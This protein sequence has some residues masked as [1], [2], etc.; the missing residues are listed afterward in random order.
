MRRRIRSG[1]KTSSRASV[2]ASAASKPTGAPAGKERRG[3]AV[4]G[5]T[6]TGTGRR[7][8]A[9]KAKKELA[10]L[11]RSLY[12][13]VL[14]LRKSHKLERVAIAFYDSQTTLQWSYNGDALFHAASTIKLA[15]LVAVYVQ[16]ARGQ[17]RTDE[18]VHVRN[19]FTSVVGG[20]P[21]AI[22]L[23]S[24]DEEVAKHVDR[25]MSVEQLAYE[26]ITKSSNLATNLL[27]D[28]VGVD[29]IKKCLDELRVDGV[30]MVRGVQDT[31]AFEA[32]INNLVTASG[33]L[34]LLRLIADGR[35]AS[36]E[37]CGQMLEILLDTK[38]R[39][40]I[41]AG[42]PGDAQVAHKTGTISTVH[43][44]AGI[45]YIGTRRPYFVVVL[46]QFPAEVGRSKAVAQ[47]AHDLFE[48]FGSLPRDLEDD[49]LAPV[50]DTTTTT[51]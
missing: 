15:V 46:T 4:A 22:D 27:V 9:E 8:T 43:H 20:N 36:P 3:A 10:A 5:G 33:I 11:E 42:A 14:R 38:A 26:M 47:I 37:A 13:S 45:V 19:R 50:V 21:Y 12:T 35:A 51:T 49:E 1:K 39:S 25:T 7:R 30:V 34:R 18:P 41:P 40:G 23:G 2:T 6:G 32:G 48:A 16:V 29:F 17:L 28:I 24:G 31:R 44:D